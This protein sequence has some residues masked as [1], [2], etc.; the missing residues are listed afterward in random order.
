[1]K[2]VILLLIV[3][4]S[5][6]AKATCPDLTKNESPDDCPWAEATRQIVDEDKTCK[7]VFKEKVPFLAKQLKK[8]SSSQ[9]F[10]N[11]WG[12]AKNFDDNAKAVIVDTKIIS[13]LAIYLQM[14][15]YLKQH[16]GFDA[17]HAGLQHTYAYL[18]SNTPT[19]YGYKRARWTKDDLRKGLWLSPDTL[20]PLTKQGSFLANVTYLFAK[21]TFGTETLLRHKNYVSSE[22]VNLDVKRFSIRHLKET[23]SEKA[24]V[25]HTNFVKLNPVNLSS[26]N[27]H[28]LIYWIEDL[29]NNKKFFISGFPVEENFM[30]KAFD[31]K[32]LGENKPIV[33]RYNSWLS[34]ITDSKEPLFG[35]REEVISSE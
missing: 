10:L 13:C 24:I 14:K 4:H 32:N 25:L 35:L 15:D 9:V 31:P 19:P 8:D 16:N 20:S 1:M 30:T 29:K 2:K 12:E 18:F 26:K 28:L 11:L 34:G 23:I 5:L 6:I 27:T 33:T 17:V 3:A 21:L 7:S 22:I